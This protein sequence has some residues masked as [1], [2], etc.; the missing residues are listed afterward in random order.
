MYTTINEEGTLNNYAR[1][2]QMYYS[3]YPSPEQ[4]RNYLK[5]GTLALLLLT[6]LL[7]T[8]LAVS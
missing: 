5:W 2:P 6:S 4:Q 1:E 3:N 7:L 8:T